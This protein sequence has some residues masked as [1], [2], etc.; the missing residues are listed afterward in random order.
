MTFSQEKL[1]ALNEDIRRERNAEYLKE[2]LNE[3]G[4]LYD[5]DE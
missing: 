5:N 3:G 2:S 4:R 1:D